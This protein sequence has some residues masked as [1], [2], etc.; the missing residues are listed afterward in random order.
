MDPTSF[1]QVFLIWMLLFVTLRNC[2]ISQMFLASVNGKRD[3]SH[4][5]WKE[6]KQYTHWDLV[7]T[8]VRHTLIEIRDRKFLLHYK[9]SFGAFN[10]LVLE[11]THF[12]QSSCLNPIKTQLE[13]KKIMAI[14]IYRF[15]HG[16]SVTHMAD[17]FNVGALTI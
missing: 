5:W 1:G 10:N 9:I 17:R 13:I 6:L 14:V 12:L 15:A 16:F 2:A 8:I 11:L 4:F 7:E 3:P